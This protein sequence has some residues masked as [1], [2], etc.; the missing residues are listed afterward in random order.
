MLCEEFDGATEL[1]EPPDELS[2][3][4]PPPEECDEPL[5]GGFG[6]VMCGRAGMVSPC[7]T[8]GGLGVRCVTPATAAFLAVPA[9][10]VPDVTF[11]SSA[12]SLAPFPPFT[13]R[14]CSGS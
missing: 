9:A 12:V 11:V 10:E 3:I 2:Q 8:A 6:G 1:D 5:E 7:A 4:A 14:C 13:K